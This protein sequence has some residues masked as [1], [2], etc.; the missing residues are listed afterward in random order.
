[1]VLD[2]TG[3]DDTYV[4]PGGRFGKGHETYLYNL[5]KRTKAILDRSGVE[6]FTIHDLR[7]TCFTEMRRLGVSREDA[8]MV[9]NHKIAGVA[10]VYDRHEGDAEK[11]RALL[12]WDREVSRIVSGQEPAS[13]KVVSIR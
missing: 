1:M 6:H 9:L 11:R 5:Q 13:E 8:D 3:R 2:Q 10:T 7:R 12:A 4:F